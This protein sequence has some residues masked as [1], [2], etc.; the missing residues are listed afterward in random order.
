MFHKSFITTAL[1]IL[2]VTSV[3]GSDTWPEQYVRKTNNQIWSLIQK[4]C[5]NALCRDHL[6]KLR[7]ERLQSAGQSSGG[8]KNIYPP[9]RNYEE[10]IR[11]CGNADSGAVLGRSTASPSQKNYNH[12]SGVQRSHYNEPAKVEKPSPVLIIDVEAKEQLAREIEASKTTKEVLTI[13]SNCMV[14]NI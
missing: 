13:M 9:P 12:V 14:I 6:N 8:C 7:N 1:G 5:T 2:F 10:R 3:Q 11:L 4:R